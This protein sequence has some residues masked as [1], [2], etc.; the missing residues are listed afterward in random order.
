[1]DVAPRRGE[2]VEGGWLRRER[3]DLLTL[4]G[5]LDDPA[6]LRPTECP[7]WDVKGVALHVL[8]DDL[9]LLSRQRDAATNGLLLYAEKHPGED[10][11]QLLDGFNEQWVTAA[12]FV[13]T[14][15]LIELL[16]MT[17][18]RTATFYDQVDLEAPGEPVGFFGSTEASPY[19]QIISRELV[20]RWVHQQQIRRAVGAPD[21]GDDLLGV[22]ADIFVR[23]IALRL[24]DIGLPV[25]ASFALEVPGVGAWSL[26]RTGDAWAL[27]VGADS[28]ATATVSFAAPTARHLFSRASGGPPEAISTRGDDAV[29]SA[30]LGALA[31]IFG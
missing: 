30:A 16:D 7:A 28:E 21:L 6:W 12:T 4:L 25:G 23:A 29:G 18:D 17:G 27:T 24:G 31:E 15:L 19:W 3:Q 1:M 10:F 8:G 26:R 2:V 20:E 11:R 5:Q 22:V 9:S 14:T 13:S